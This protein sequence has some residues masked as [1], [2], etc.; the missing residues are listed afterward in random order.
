[1]PLT[2][3]VHIETVKIDV[4]VSIPSQTRQFCHV[5]LRPTTGMHALSFANRP[6]LTRK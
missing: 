2:D 1:M 5:Q 4:M 6:I 3:H